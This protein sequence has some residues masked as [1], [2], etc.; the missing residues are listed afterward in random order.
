MKKN[1]LVS[2]IIPTYNRAS[3]IKDTIDSVMFQTYDNW[4][5][6][7][8]DDNSTDETFKIVNEYIKKD[9]RFKFIQKK[10]TDNRGASKSRNI[11]LSIAKGDY[12]QFLDSDDILAKNK[13]EKQLELL[14]KESHFTLSTCKWGKFNSIS[15]ELDLFENKSDY[16]TFENGKEYFDLIGVHGGFY[17]HHCFLIPKLLISKAGFWNESLTINDDGEFF[18]R[19]LLSADKIVFSRYTHILYREHTVNNLSVLDS[20]SKAN[21]LLNSWKIIESLYQTKYNEKNPAY[22]LKKKTAVYNELKKNN[23]KLINTNKHFFKEQIRNDNF[24]LKLN[25]LG[26]RIRN[27]F[28]KIILK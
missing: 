5:C 6:I 15:D 17:P 19:I 22:L 9:G 10:I 16:K 28:K 24:I 25:K 11:G 2:V 21:S 1:I 26:R 18:F 12:I 13:I 20:D 3:L 7:I 14:E 4:E 27:K 23:I 8:I